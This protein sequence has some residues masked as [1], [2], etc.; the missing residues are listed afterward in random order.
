MPN[1]YVQMLVHEMVVV[2]IIYLANLFIPRI[3]IVLVTRLLG[4]YNDE[5]KNE[6][7]IN[8]C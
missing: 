1:M 8:A 5:R 2:T 3:V 4:T 7:H 6:Y